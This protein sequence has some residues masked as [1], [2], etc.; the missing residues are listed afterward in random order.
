M[1]VNGF[2]GL[3]T[4][5]AQENLKTFGFNELST[6]QPKSIWR[7]AFEVIKHH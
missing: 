3:T 2:I 6:T 7:I 4:T 1:G 5:Q